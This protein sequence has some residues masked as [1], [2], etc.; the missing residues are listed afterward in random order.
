MRANILVIDAE[1]SI[2]FGFSR[3]LATEGRAVSACLVAARN[4][5]KNTNK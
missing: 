2:R 5:R 4:I 3:F 1:E